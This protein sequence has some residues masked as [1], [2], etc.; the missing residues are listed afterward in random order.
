MTESWL[1]VS[2]I[3]DPDLSYAAVSGLRVLTTAL[4]VLMLLR[5]GQVI[6]TAN[7]THPPFTLLN[8][9]EYG[10]VERWRKPIVC[11]VIGVGV[12]AV[13]FIVQVFAG[14]G[15]PQSPLANLTPWL[16]ITYSALMTM[17]LGFAMAFGLVKEIILVWNRAPRAPRA[18]VQ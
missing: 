2:L 17:S 7:S 10:G 16:L 1:N 3:R 12:M 4:L 14:Q 5:L 6:R 9:L 11:I 8:L 18:G 15:S 13:S